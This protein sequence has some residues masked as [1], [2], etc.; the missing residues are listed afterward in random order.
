MP[1]TLRLSPVFYQYDS[2]SNLI[3]PQAAAQDEFK[4]ILRD[5]QPEP[6]PKDVLAELDQILVIAEGVAENIYQDQ[7]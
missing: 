6:L 7:K 1:G 4:R 3:D 5:H 2:A